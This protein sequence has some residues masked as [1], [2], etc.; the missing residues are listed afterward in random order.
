ML[1]LCLHVKRRIQDLIGTLLMF[2]LD[3]NVTEQIMQWAMTQAHQRKGTVNYDR[4]KLI[5]RLL[6]GLRAPTVGTHY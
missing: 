3:A 4:S 5:L 2:I 6:Q 1:G